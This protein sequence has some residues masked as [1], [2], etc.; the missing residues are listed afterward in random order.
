MDINLPGIKHIL[1][2][3]SRQITRY[4]RLFMYSSCVF[5]FPEK[6]FNSLAYKLNQY[7]HDLIPFG[8]VYLPHFVHLFKK[9]ATPSLG[10]H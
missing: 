6:L 4:G 8:L 9:S 7:V 5:Q 2:F 1:A 3:D 10:S